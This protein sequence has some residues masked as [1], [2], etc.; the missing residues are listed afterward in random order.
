MELI[1]FFVMISL[2]F[3]IGGGCLCIID[4]KQERD[5][6]ENALTG[7]ILLIGLAEPVHIYGAFMGHS[8]TECTRYYL[9]IIAMA[10]LLTGLIFFCMKHGKKDQEKADR[11]KTQRMTENKTQQKVSVVSGKKESKN[12]VRS[13]MKKKQMKEPLKE[14]VYWLYTV[15]AFLIIIQLCIT[16]AENQ[17]GRFF[18]ETDVTPE[19]V[20]SFLATDSIYQSNP[21]TGQAYESGMPSRLR[22]LDLSTVYAMIVRASGVGMEAL[23]YVVIPLLVITLFYLAYYQLAKRLFDDETEKALFMVVVAV[24]VM[25]G[26]YALPLDGA[27][28]LYD[29]HTGLAIRNCVLVPYTIAS[30][31]DGN[32]K[33][34]V[35]CIACEACIAWT[36][37]GC[38]VCFLI[39]VSFL[40]IRLILK[41]KEAA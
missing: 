6:R 38:G 30:A 31:L 19:T 41:K 25:A 16:N 26:T 39:G 14:S 29:S 3:L 33:K 34:V 18:T 17:T 37:Y 7:A 13:M 11:E 22:I 28:L 40:M 35:L 4:R 9:V 20:Q 24:V 21:L 1:L 2:A 15:L 12:S 36:L 23:L 8:L 5:W 32:W 27:Q 10:L